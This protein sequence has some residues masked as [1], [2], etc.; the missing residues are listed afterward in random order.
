MKT[1]NLLILGLATVLVACSSGETNV[2]AGNQ[3]GILH[4]G[5]GTEPQTIDPHLA[6]GKPGHHVIMALFEGL[7]TKNPYSLEVEPGV[8]DSWSVSEDG[9][10][11]RF[12]IREGASW[13]DGTLITAEDFRWSWRRI[14]HPEFGALYNYMLFPILNAE[15]FSTGQ[16]EDFSEVGV[17][18]LDE[19]TL[20]VELANPT[21]YFLQLLDHP[22]MF[23]VPRHVVEQHGS[24]TSQA[25]TW[26][27]A[28][29]IVGNGAFEMVEWNLN[30]S[31]SVGKSDSYWDSENVELNGIVFYP[32]DSTITE[33]RM[34][35][36]GQ[37]HRTEDFPIERYSYYLEERP[38]VLRA[39]PY[40]G[41]YFYLFNTEREP[42]SDSRVRR[43]LAM[44]ID[45]D[46]LVE[47]VLQ[48]L[49]DPAF[50]I[51]PPGALGY[52][53]PH[54]FNF[55]P[56]AAA[57][58]LAEAGYPDGQGFPGFEILYNTLE[59]HQRVAEVV[60]QMWRTYL[61]INVTLTNQEWRV[62]LDSISEGNYDIAR[63]SWLGD[64]VDPNSFLD[65]WITGGG[66]N[67]TGWSDPVYDRMILQEAP[68]AETR[69]QRFAIFQEA[70][71]RLMQ[72]MPLMPIYIYVTKHLV[73]PSVQGMPPNILD[74][75]N[76]K[77]VSLGE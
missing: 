42:L 34:F 77:Y 67:R 68:Q 17:R 9:K 50:A 27:R 35:R 28:E 5:N 70:E 72:A 43:A 60:Q 52:E 48:G 75:Y 20:E 59:G 61:N 41:T 19:H 24:A 29:N 6:T 3:A 66:N 55:D 21:P 8:A 71:S 23:A 10:I 49:N 16:L 11:Y 56:E 40:L 12:H 22:S 64:Y 65:M 18:V 14:L 38:E 76:Y 13:S 39:T 47:S 74:H 32:T 37:L 2:E 44:A 57:A 46:Q 33:E 51:T 7:V 45:R 53:P 15:A 73:D 25:N 4:F 1:I 58:L 62:Y 63:A 31:L 36:S 54:T 30:Q 69:E 26:T